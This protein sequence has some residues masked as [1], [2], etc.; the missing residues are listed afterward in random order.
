[1]PRLVQVTHGLWRRAARAARLVAYDAFFGKR[2]GRVGL[3]AGISY[4]PRMS[5]SLGAGAQLGRN[6]TFQG[7]GRVQIGARTYLGGFFSIHCVRAVTIGDDCLVGNFVSIVDNDHGTDASA[8]IAAQPLAAKP[9]RIGNGCW[10]GE[11]ATVLAGVTIGDGA[12]VGAGAVVTRDVPAGAIVAGVPAR[13]LRLRALGA[14]SL[15]LDGV[16][17]ERGARIDAER[18]EDHF[19]VI[20]HREDAAAERLRDLAGRGAG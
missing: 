8:P 1:V 19:D 12:V 14:G 3:A 11:K 10:L 20:A 17:D 7:E 9:V 6:G 15:G 13:V 2:T 4:D 18:R 16:G 5:L